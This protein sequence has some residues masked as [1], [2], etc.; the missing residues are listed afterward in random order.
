MDL[1]CLHP[2]LLQHSGPSTTQVDT[3][4]AGKLDGVLLTACPY[5]SDQLVLWPRV[6]ESLESQ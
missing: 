1:V 6:E 5:A 4:T 2:G 3:K